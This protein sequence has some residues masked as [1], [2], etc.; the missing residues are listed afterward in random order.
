MGVSKSEA[1]AII[2]KARNLGTEDLEIPQC[3]AVVEDK[4]EDELALAIRLRARNYSTV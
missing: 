4:S 3:D 1:K 2:A